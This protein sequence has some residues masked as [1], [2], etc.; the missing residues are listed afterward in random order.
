LPVGAAIVIFVIA[1]NRGRK[2]LIMAPDTS[3]IFSL[4][5]AEKLQLV[6]DLWDDLASNPSA[7]PVH[8]WQIALLNDR[9]ARLE[10]MPETAISWEE[11][12]DRLRALNRGH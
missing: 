3:S 10:Q 4:G 2:G 7:V 5:P 9:R 1:R 11:M 12:Q 6:E 8:D